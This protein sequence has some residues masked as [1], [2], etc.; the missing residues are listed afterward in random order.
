MV[1]FVV[2]V[3]VESSSAE[4]TER[5]LRN[6]LTEGVRWDRPLPI[7]YIGEACEIGAARRYSTEEVHLL[8]DG[9]RTIAVPGRGV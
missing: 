6:M 3:V 8:R 1:C 7:P 2:P 5:F 9:M 4:E